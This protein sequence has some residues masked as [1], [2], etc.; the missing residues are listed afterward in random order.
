[1]ARIRLTLAQAIV[2]FLMNQYVEQDGQS[3]PFFA[4]LWGI[5]GHGNIGGI[6]QAA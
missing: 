1:M 5:F 4:G 3:Q 2:R 6:A